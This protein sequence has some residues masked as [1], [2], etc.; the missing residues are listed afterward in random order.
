MK[1]KHMVI[2]V[3]IPHK[4]CPYDCIYCNQKLISGQQ[5]DITEEEMVQVIE[6]YL[7]SLDPRRTFVEIGFYGGSFTGI[8]RARQIQLLD[9]ARAYVKRGLV[10]EIRLST[11]PDYISEEILAY[12]KEYCVNTI[13]LGVQSLDQE[14]LRKSSRGHGAEASIVASQLIKK[15]GIKL[16]IQ[17]MIG[18]PG[19]TMEKDLCTARKVIEMRPDV[20]RIYPTLVIKNTYM[21]KLYREG[22][23]IPLELEEAVEI[24]SA[25]LELYKQNNIKVIR[26]GLQPTDNINL[27]MDVVAGPFHPAFRQL[28]ESRLTLSRMEKVIIESGLDKADRIAIYVQ[29]EKI[30]DA[31]G[32]RRE[33]ISYLKKKFKFTEIYILPDETL[34]DNIYANNYYKN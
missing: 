14:V 21:E 8:D 19:D 16:G 26:I 20:V 10:R 17:T 28:V 24:S 5:E 15:S 25:L 12:L 33:N 23:Y 13:E 34:I 22:E 6:R 11:R 27:G 30:S 9:V 29:K 1:S 4:G 32:H 2:P 3:F 7:S 31:I 18:L